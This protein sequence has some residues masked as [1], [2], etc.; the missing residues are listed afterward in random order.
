M[1]V[2]HLDVQLPCKGSSPQARHCRSDPLTQAFNQTLP[3]V[4]LQLART[5]EFSLLTPPLSSFSFCTA[6]KL[7]TSNWIAIMK[8]L[9]WEIVKASRVFENHLLIQHLRKPRQWRRKG[10]LR[11]RAGMKSQCPNSQLHVCTLSLPGGQN[12]REW[13]GHR[14]S[15]LENGNLSRVTAVLAPCWGFQGGLGPES[16]SSLHLLLRESWT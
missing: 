13:I 15:V 4:C 1:L 12:F 14:A 5:C 3:S 6:H 10:S 8:F 11:G 9:S 7:D 16:H 2:G